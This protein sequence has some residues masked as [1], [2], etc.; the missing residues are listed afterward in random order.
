MRTFKTV[1]A[2]GDI[3]ITKISGLPERAVRVHPEG[4]RVIVTHSETGHH[5]VMDAVRVEM[6]RLPDDIM[7]CLLVVN[8]PTALE[9]LRDCDKHEPILFEKGVYDVRRQREYTPEGFRRVED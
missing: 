3:Y 2:Q 6:Y 1:C 7:N 8:D 9:H 4:N 5:H